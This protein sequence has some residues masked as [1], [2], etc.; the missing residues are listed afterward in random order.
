M[1][2]R[3]GSVPRFQQKKQPDGLRGS[4]EDSPVA[5]GASPTGKIRANTAHLVCERAQKAKGWQEKSSNEREAATE[6]KG[7]RARAEA[8]KIT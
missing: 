8:S 3:L 5:W 7:D 2:S 1:K 4:P 6:P